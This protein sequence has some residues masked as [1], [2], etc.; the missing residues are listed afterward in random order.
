MAG[1]CS[2]DLLGPG[3]AKNALNMQGERCSGRKPHLVFFYIPDQL[4]KNC[5]LL[6]ELYPS[7]VRD[8]RE[9][10]NEQPDRYEG[11]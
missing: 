8:S 11:M 10:F 5:Y 1:E 4:K 9:L 6:N 7:S 2:G 3:W